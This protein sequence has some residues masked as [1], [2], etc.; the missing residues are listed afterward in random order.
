MSFQDHQI[1]SGKIKE[2]IYVMCNIFGILYI[3][4]Q[5]FIFFPQFFQDC[6]VKLCAFSINLLGVTVLSICL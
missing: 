6:A 5:I 4:T 3:F 2:V 1:L